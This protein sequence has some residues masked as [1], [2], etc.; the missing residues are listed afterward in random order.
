MAGLGLMVSKCSSRIKVVNFMAQL[1]LE[2]TISRLKVGDW[3]DE[4]GFMGITLNDFDLIL[5]LKFFVKARAIA[6]PY[7]R[8]LFVMDEI[9]LCFV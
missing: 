4:C 3:K 7:L 2:T 1:I 8:G 5:G 6:I 9:H